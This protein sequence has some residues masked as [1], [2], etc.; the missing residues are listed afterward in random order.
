MVVVT[1]R[2]SVR[3]RREYLYRR[4][5]EGKEKEL[6]EKKSRVRE[7][8]A[9]GKPIP[10]E[11]KDEET[12]LRRLLAFDDAGVLKGG[13]LALDDEYARTLRGER[14]AKICV[15]SSRDPSARL[16]KFVKELKHLF[17]NSTNVNRGNTTVADLVDATRRAEFTDLV[18]VHE[19]RGK[20]D[21]LVVSHLP[22]G[23]TT[24]FTL[25]NCVLRHDVQDLPNFSV[26]AAPHLVFHNFD[27]DKKLANRIKTVLKCLFPIAG[28]SSNKD[29]KRIVT[30]YNQDDTISFRHHHHN[31]QTKDNNVD[32][33]E[34]GP[35]FDMFPY[36]IKLGT[37]ETSA[38]SDVEWVLRPYLNSAKAIL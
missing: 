8:L 38:S 26:D 17:P 32:L 30:F 14:G 21:G 3:L 34:L 18:V 6:F 24:Y 5:L 13:P 28:A 25:S 33:Q 11:L 23:P 29:N 19:T 7:A 16:K 35:R 36:Q 22:V 27:K 37:L 1:N 15:T 2:R 31:Q 10:S 4:S 9:S 12:E 20:P